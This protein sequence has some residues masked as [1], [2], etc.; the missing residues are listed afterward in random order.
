MVG[1]AEDHKN[2]VLEVARI[3]NRQDV[4]SQ[5]YTRYP[6]DAEDAGV[7]LFGFYLVMFINVVQSLVGRYISK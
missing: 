1:V 2:L 5:I 3:A 6:G 7:N 4:Y